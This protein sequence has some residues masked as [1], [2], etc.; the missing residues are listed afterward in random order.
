MPGRANSQAVPAI[1]C[2]FAA[3]HSSLLSVLEMN[4]P[5][6]AVSR[7]TPRF[8]TP[9]K[10]MRSSAAAGCMSPRR[11]GVAPWSR[12]A[13]DF[14]EQVVN[15]AG[16]RTGDAD[17]AAGFQEMRDQPRAGPRLP[18]AGRSLNEQVAVV[19][20]AHEP[21]LRFE[22]QRLNRS[23][24]AGSETRRVASKDVLKGRVRRSAS[25]GRLRHARD[26]LSLCR[27]RDRL[28]GDNRLRQG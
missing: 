25:Y 13:L 26:R 8:F 2:T 1:S 18:A 14:R 3:A 12:A 4:R 10:S 28:A 17:A 9:L 15:R 20:L 27:V 19:Q 6:N 23:A 24:S 21:A 11:L 7:L 5:S 16:A 22:I